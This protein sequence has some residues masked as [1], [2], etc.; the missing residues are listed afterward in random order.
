MLSV[1]IPAGGEDPDGG[2]RRNLLELLGCIGRQAYRDY[3]VVLVEEFLDGRVYGDLEVDKYVPI[4][5]PGRG[6]NLAWARNVGARSAAGDKHLQLDADI[7]FGPDYLGRVAECDREAFHAWDKLYRLTEDGARAWLRSRSF[8][9]LLKDASFVD[10]REGWKGLEHRFKPLRPNVWHTAGVAYCFDRDFFFNRFG[11]FN[12]NFFG[13]G[14]MDNDAALRFTQL[15]GEHYKLPD[16]TAFHLPHEGRRG[17]SNADEWEHTRKNLTQVSERLVKA[18]LGKRS[19][20][21][22]IRW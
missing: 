2:R 5:A 8:D 20:P 15:V 3:E 21:T 14:G 10:A 4:K 19:G 16:C 1:I 9:G 17:G 11:G 22:A 13:W 7:I 18:G 6:F 12:E